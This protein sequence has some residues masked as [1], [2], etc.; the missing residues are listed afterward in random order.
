MMHAATD[1][2]VQAKKARIKAVLVEFKRFKPQIFV[3]NS[4][5]LWIVEQWVERMEKL[6]QDLY[7]KK[8]NKVHLAAHCLDSGANKWCGRHLQGHYE[9]LSEP[10]WR[11]FKE[12]IYHRYLKDTTKENMERDLE[13][14][15]QGDRTVHENE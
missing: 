11:E 6:F 9:G 15:R 8:P 7:T 3:G 12:A 4:D 10:W 1:D 2:A 13:N 5:D 14:I